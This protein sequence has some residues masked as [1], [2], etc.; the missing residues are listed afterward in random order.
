MLLWVIIV[1][2]HSYGVKNQ[3]NLVLSTPEVTKI[4]NNITWQM[5][6]KTFIQ[7]LPDQIFFFLMENAN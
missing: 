6:H 3:H 1:F 4:P 7:Y 5:N 2:Q